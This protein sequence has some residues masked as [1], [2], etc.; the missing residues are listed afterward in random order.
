[1]KKAV[2]LL[3]VLLLPMAVGAQRFFRLTTTSD[4]SR[5]LLMETGKTAKAPGTAHIVTLQ[6]S[7]H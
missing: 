4:R 1:M 2:V 6:A 5:S 3:C 7:E